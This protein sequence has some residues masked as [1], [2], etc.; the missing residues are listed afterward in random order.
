MSHYLSWHQS[1]NAPL[2]I[3]TMKHKPDFGA[4]T[5]DIERAAHDWLTANLGLEGE[6]VMQSLADVM[7]RFAIRKVLTAPTPWD[8]R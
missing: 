4:P 6:A 3:E 1:S 8:N 5:D 7:R 2:R